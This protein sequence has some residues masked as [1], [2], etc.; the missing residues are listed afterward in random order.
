MARLKFDLTPVVPWWFRDAETRAEHDQSIREYYE[1]CWPGRAPVPCDCGYW[2]EGALVHCPPDDRAFC[3]KDVPKRLEQHHRYLHDQGLKKKRAFPGVPFPRCGQGNCC[4]C[5]KPMVHGRVK[6]RSAHDGRKDEPNCRH[7]WNLHVR[8][9][10]QQAHLL[11]RDGM[12]CID[13][14]AVVGTWKGGW[15][16]ETDP[17]SVRAWGPSW[18]IR[19]PPETY[20]APFCWANWNT[21]LEVDHFIALAVAYMAFPEDARRR[22][23]FSPANLRLLCPACHVAKTGRDRLLLRQAA[24]FGPEWLKG[25]VLRQLADAGLLRTPGPKGAP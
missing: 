20:V 5:G 2:V 16:R 23:F 22:W 10:V 12:G 15:V 19:C 25:E 18:V 8:L 7:L 1:R 3:R 13:C 9:D 11:D 24:A 14:G 21:H 17:E 6:Q 4:W